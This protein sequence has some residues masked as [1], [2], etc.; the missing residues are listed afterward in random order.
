MD[1]RGLPFGNVGRKNQSEI[2]RVL[3]RL[4]AFHIALEDGGI[5]KSVKIRR[6]GL[7]VFLRSAAEITHRNAVAAFVVVGDSV[8]RHMQIA[9]KMDDVA[10]RIGSLVRVGAV[11][12]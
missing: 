7:M 12:L 11:V 3:R 2:F 4:G 5:P 8:K 9:D 10:Q 1:S 6:K